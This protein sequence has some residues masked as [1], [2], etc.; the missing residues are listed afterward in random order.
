MILVGMLAMEHRAQLTG[1]LPGRLPTGR[2]WNN[3]TQSSGTPGA[4]TRS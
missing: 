4:E 1:K 3:H 2:N